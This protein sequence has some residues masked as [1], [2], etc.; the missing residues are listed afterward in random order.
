MKKLHEGCEKF[1]AM[2]DWNQGYNQ[3]IFSAPSSAK[4]INNINA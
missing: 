1:R 2:P 4:P 3:K